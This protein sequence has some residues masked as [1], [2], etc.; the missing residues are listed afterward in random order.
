MY[1]RAARRFRKIMMSRAMGAIAM[2][3]A[4]KVSKSVR[5]C[6]NQWYSGLPGVVRAAQSEEWYRGMSVWIK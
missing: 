1:R 5:G 2:T 4:P 6:H 3:T